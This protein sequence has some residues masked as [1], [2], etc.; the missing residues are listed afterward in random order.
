MKLSYFKLLIL[1]QFEI[2]PHELCADNVKITLSEITN[3]SYFAIN[4]RKQEE[5]PLSIQIQINKKDIDAT[6]Y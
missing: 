2:K 4:K 1:V 5:Y 6:T 3:K